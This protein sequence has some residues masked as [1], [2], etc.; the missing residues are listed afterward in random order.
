VLVHFEH[1]AKNLASLQTR[2]VGELVAQVEQLREGQGNDL[3]EVG[4]VLPRLEPVDL[5]YGQQTLYTREDGLDVS[6]IEQLHCDV[7]EVGPFLGE[8]I[9]ED[10]LQSRDKLSANV[11]LGSDEDGDETVLEGLLLVVGDRLGLAEL[12]GGTPALGHAILEIYNSWARSVGG[13]GS[14]RTGAGRMLT[15]QAD[16]RFLLIFQY[17]QQGV[18]E[19]GLLFSLDGST[20]SASSHGTVPIVQ[21][22]ER[23]C[24]RS[25]SACWRMAALASSV[26]LTRSRKAATSMV[27]AS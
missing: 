23:T 11:G 18:G 26:F 27:A 3:V 10:F 12:L 2:L 16:G 15:R 7:E 20:L 6:G 14:I 21:R 25:S 8:I 24:L 1:S 4:A 13:V 22:R 9:G 5:A 19:A 17:V